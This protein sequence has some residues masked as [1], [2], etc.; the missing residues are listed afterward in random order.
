LRSL[1]ATAVAVMDSVNLA[2]PAGQ[3]V[4][5]EELNRLGEFRVRV[6][7]CLG[8]RADELFELTDALA[9]LVAMHLH[10]LGAGE[11][12]S[13]TFVAD[14]APWIWDRIATIVKLAKLEGVAIH[15]VLDCCHAAHHISLALAALGQTHEERMPLIVRSLA[16]A[17]RPMAACGRGTDRASRGRAAG[18]QD[19]FAFP[20]LDRVLVITGSPADASGLDALWNAELARELEL[21]TEKGD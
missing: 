2:S 6:Y 3:S 1:E 12:A 18:E 7:R 13:V 19:L 15:E 10:R 11:A 16:I 4:A 8:R 14:G 5:A 20:G 21:N 17:Q 9:E